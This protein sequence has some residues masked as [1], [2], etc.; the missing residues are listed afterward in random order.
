MSSVKEKKCNGPC[1]LVKPVSE[2]NADRKAKD[3]YQYKCRSC[4]SKYQKENK[5]KLRIKKVQYKKDNPEYV[6]KQ[7]EKAAEWFK[8]NP[9]YK[10]QWYQ[11]NKG[12]ISISRAKY[13][14]DNTDVLKARNA[15]SRAARLKRAVDWADDWK[16]RQF[17]IVAQKLTDM[18]GVE[19][20]VDHIIPLQGKLVSGLHVENNL[21]IITA[22]E[23]LRKH[24]K[25]IPG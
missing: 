10:D 9:D 4:C 6:A 25:F 21:Q 20:H 15:K 12:A 22:T 2:F 8:N 13:Y 7:R 18:Y 17:Y 24:N 5:E 19:F 16:I 3:G 11:D 23:N 1:E 14:K